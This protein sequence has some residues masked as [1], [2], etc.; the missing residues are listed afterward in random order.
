MDAAERELGY[1]PVTTYP[2]AV[3]ETC[4]WVVGELEGGHSWEGTYLEAMFDYAAEDEALRSR[5]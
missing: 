5:A 1:R 2:E 4:A 3:R